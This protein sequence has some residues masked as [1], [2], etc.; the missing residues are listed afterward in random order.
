LDFLAGQMIMMGFKGYELDS[1]LM[2]VLRRVKPCGLV[3]FQRNIRGLT[4]VKR[5]IGEI[6]DYASNIGLPK[7]LVALDHEG[8]VV[9]RS[10]RLTPLPSAMA[11][12][13]SGDPSNVEGAARIAGEELKA[14]GFNVNFAP[15]ADLNTN[16]RNPVIGLRSFG[17]DPDTVSVMVSKYVSTLQSI[18]VMATAKHFPGHGDT[19]IDSHLDLPKVDVDLDLLMARE[20]KPFKAAIDADV[21]LIM[22]SHV[23]FPKIDETGLPATLSK[24]ILRDILRGLLKFNGLIISD[25]LEM[26]A[27][28]GRFD[29]GEVAFHGLNAGLNV[30]LRCDDYDSVFELKDAIIK[31][32][33]G[34]RVDQSVLYDSYARIEAV[35]GRIKSALSL[36]PPVK[37]SQSLFRRNRVASRDISL[38]AITLL[39]GEAFKPIKD[40]N[41]IVILIP[42]P[43][44]RFLSKF[45][46]DVVGMVVGEFG[47]YVENIVLYFYDE[48]SPI[49]DIL[50]ASRNVD[51]VIFF[52]YNAIFNDF[53]MDL[54]RIVRDRVSVIVVAGLPYDVELIGD[55]KPILLTYGLN[56]P[57]LSALVDVLCGFEGARGKLPVKL[58]SNASG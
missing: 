40:L 49:D 16:P 27:I 8:G 32:V 33:R 36:H 58:K 15:V 13:A 26:K 34:G 19:S 54:Y 38:N 31:C 2:D 50:E 29:A 30:F 22:T 47:S 43:L 6:Q 23:S 4:H 24:K 28:S 52:T 20:L 37:L 51:G 7:L 53:Q 55:S 35:R 3:L 42:K 17:D 12:G 18:G 9:F 44:E 5:L 57:S 11:L 14:L 1:E 45:D 21:A 10:E 46:Y 41:S 56:P 39:N 48:S 25:A